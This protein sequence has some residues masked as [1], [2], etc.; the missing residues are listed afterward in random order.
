MT[1]EN[2]TGPYSD[3]EHYVNSPQ[4]EGTQKEGPSLVENPLL[5]PTDQSLRAKTNRD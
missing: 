1:Y 3:D 4:K 2:Q 5:V